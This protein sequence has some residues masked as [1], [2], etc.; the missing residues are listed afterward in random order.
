[1][2]DGISFRSSQSY[3]VGALYGGVTWPGDYVVMRRAPGV[4]GKL[5]SVVIERGDWLDFGAMNLS[6]AGGMTGALINSETLGALATAASDLRA[7]SYHF[8]VAQFA[9]IALSPGST[10]ESL[11]LN[12]SRQLPAIVRPWGK[13]R[14]PKFAKAPDAVSYD[15]ASGTVNIKLIPD[16]PG[17][18]PGTVVVRTVSSLSDGGKREIARFDGATV[19][20]TL[21][22]TPPPDLA[23]ADTRWQLTRQISL[24]GIDNSGELRRTIGAREDAL[25]FGN[26]IVRLEFT[27]SAPALIAALT[28]AGVQFT[29][30]NKVVGEVQLLDGPPPDGCLAAA[31]AQPLAL[32]PAPGGALYVAGAGVV[33]A[34]DMVSLKRIDTIAI[35]GGGPITSL[36]ATDNLLF[37]GQGDG[38][39]GAGGFRLLAMFSTSQSSRYHRDPIALK[40]PRPAAA[41]LRVDGMDMGADGRTLVMAV[42]GPPEGGA[43]ASGQVWVLDLDSLNLKTGDIAAPL[44]APGGD[45]AAPL[46]ISAAR[47]NPDRYLVSSPNGRQAIL[48]LTRN[49]SRQ[50]TQ[51]ALAGVDARQPET[52]ADVAHLENAINADKSD[53]IALTVPDG[54]PFA[55]Y[56]KDA[57]R[58]IS[59]YVCGPCLQGRC[60]CKR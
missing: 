8:E 25:E 19:G 40:L 12:V 52:A 24:K 48:Q 37:I 32:S 22:I 27:K 20:D 35:A 58:S 56:K 44:A 13:V 17:R 46:E 16:D 38:P 26:D 11:A 53:Y 6:L 39:A 5:M 15:E 45:L 4:A 42:S 51:A 1:M 47:G 29:R 28:C 36:L 23:L 14:H 9:R 21:R 31:K 60:P 3:N 2:P 50:V 33:Y 54:I 30:G 59:T 57:P 49:G 18:L 43:A 7:G 34:I 55:A 41:P 10:G